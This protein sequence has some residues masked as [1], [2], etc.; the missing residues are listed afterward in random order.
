MKAYSLFLFL[1]SVGLGGC[2]T[3][4]VATQAEAV[5]RVRG[6]VLAHGP[7]TYLRLDSASARPAGDWWYVHVPK[8]NCRGCVPNNYA[9]RVRKQ[10]GRVVHT[11]LK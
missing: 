11:P 9:F 3:T 4:Q 6:W 7:A 5:A 2:R 10:S 8:V 1:V